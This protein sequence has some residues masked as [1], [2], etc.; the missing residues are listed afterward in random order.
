MGPAI[1]DVLPLAVGVA[2]SPV[3]I[4]A[5]VLMLATPRGRANGIAFSLG[6]VA[7]L[8]IVSA[9]V[10]AA[11]GGSAA[12]DSGEPATWSSVLKLAIGALFLLLALRQWRGRPAPGEEPA[13]PR[14]MQ[15]IDDFAAGK[16][17]GLGAV[18]S[19][20]NPKNLG[21]TL[22]AALAVAQAG[23]STGEEVGVMAIYVALASVTIVGPVVLS[24]AL[25]ERSR[26][27]LDGLRVWMTAHNAA[28]MT[29]LFVVI[30]AKLIGDGIR[31]LTA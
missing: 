17:L 31:G 24:L 18:L 14:W 26:S 8:A 9:I 3:P 6:W 30:G 20:V 7:G 23:L 4:I 13:L 15:T 22:A 5:V 29:V 1:G 27:L 16:S 12:T 2:L 11:G 25:G 10:L 28:I 21:L 19:G